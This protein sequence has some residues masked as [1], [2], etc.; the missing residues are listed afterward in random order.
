MSSDSILLFSVKRTASSQLGGRARRAGRT[1]LGAAAQPSCP[2]QL[3]IEGC[4]S[5]GHERTD[6]SAPAAPRRERT[7][8]FSADR[9]HRV[10]P[11]A[12]GIEGT[13][14]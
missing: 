12:P 3:G 6:V 13:V 5:A 14:A 9:A 4:L 10:A 2:R 8:D 11:R 1:R 7:L